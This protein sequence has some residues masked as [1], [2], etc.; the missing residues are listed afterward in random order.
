MPSPVSTLLTPREAVRTIV[1]AISPLPTIACPLRQ[2]Y[3]AV[4]GATV[5]SPIDIPPWDNSAMD[6]Y[7]ARSDDVTEGAELTIVETV[8]AGA[9]P[10]QPVPPGTCTRLFT[11]SPIPH[12]ADCVV[13]QEDV[14]ST[15]QRIR[16]TDARDRGRNVRKR[17]EDVRAGDVVVAAG[18]ELGPA[19]LGAL[20]AAAQATVTVHRRPRVAILASGDEIVDLDRV[21]DI[22]A[23]RK[24]ASSNSYSLAALV[25]SAGGDVMELG[26]ARDDRRDIEARIAQSR[27]ADLL[28]TAAG[29]SVGE[30]DHLRQLLEQLGSDLGFWRLR[31]RPGA[32]VGFGML[33]GTPWIGL[34]GNPVSAMVTFELFVRP[35]IR[36]LRGLVEIYRLAQPVELGERVETPGRLQHFLRARLEYRARTI[37]LARLT[38]GQGSGILSS[39]VKADA[40]LMVPEERLAADAGEIVSALLLNDH[41]FTSDIPY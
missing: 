37:P 25:R 40:L 12:D 5:H 16:I 21:D 33:D 26:I 3:G 11:G 14:E 38:G 7:A 10:S 29:M 8:P 20:A 6:G 4:L 2:A 34:P 19:Q 23:A 9:F 15:G 32:P 17:G 28:V 36:R 31:S 35:A 18:A 30:H 1:A 22:L 39:M 13:R 27:D 24:I 41:R